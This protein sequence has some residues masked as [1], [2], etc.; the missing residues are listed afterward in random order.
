MK[1]KILLVVFS[2]LAQAAFPQISVSDSESKVKFKDGRT[3]RYYIEKY[4]SDN[5]KSQLSHM[6]ITGLTILSFKVDTSGSIKD[7]KISTGTNAELA[8]FIY[9]MLQLQV[10]I[11]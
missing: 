10:V 8:A 11:G 4:F 7:I 2:F 1:N 9:K 5:F 6:G 3:P